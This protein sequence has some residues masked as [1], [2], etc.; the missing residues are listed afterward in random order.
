MSKKCYL[1]TLN[2]NLNIESIR[3]LLK[4]DY[5]FVPKAFSGYTNTNEYKNIN[6]WHSLS[7]TSILNEKVKYFRAEATME[8][9]RSSK[10]FYENSTLIPK[11]IR[12]NRINI[13]AIF[14]EI[15]I[16][17]DICN[18]YSIIESSDTQLKDIRTHLFGT[19]QELS[20]SGFK[21]K[22]GISSKNIY[23][24]FTE[25]FF[26]WILLKKEKKENYLDNIVIMDINYLDDKHEDQN[27]EHKTS[28][29]DILSDLLSSVA[30][31]LEPKLLSLGILA[32]TKF[33]RFN[34][35]LR[36][37]SSVILKDTNSFLKKDDLIIPITQENKYEFYL[38]I[39]GYLLP[40]LID[41]FH[42]KKS[43]LGKFKDEKS[44]FLRIQ[45]KKSFLRLANFLG[46]T[47]K[48]FNYEDIEEIKVVIKEKNEVKVE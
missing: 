18:I 37:D 15:K 17:K 1:L 21:E 24:N 32:E 48:V 40:N 11:E 43:E 26:L 8:V 30:L 13:S 25:D 10:F 9:T 34:F 16:S 4:E 14:L 39:Y 47:D 27:R 38:F 6:K 22:W 35:I 19:K 5:S 46:Y 2:K 7:E 28:G 33:G 3:E 29:D 44:I 23:L 41:E 31:T 42:Q 20:D 36:E 45:G 12:V